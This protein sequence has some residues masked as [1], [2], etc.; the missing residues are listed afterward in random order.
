VLSVATAD[1]QIIFET[2][3]LAQLQTQLNAESD[4]LV[5][6]LAATPGTSKTLGSHP[7]SSPL[8]VNRLSTLSLAIPVLTPFSLLEPI[9]RRRKQLS[10]VSVQRL[11][12]TARASMLVTYGASASGALFSWLAQLD[13]LALVSSETAIGLGILSLVASVAAGQRLWHIAQRRFWKD[14]DRVT[15]MLEGDLKVSALQFSKLNLALVHLHTRVSR[16]RQASVN[17]RWIG[18]PHKKTGEGVGQSTRHSRPAVGSHDCS[19]TR[20]A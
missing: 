14:F 20:P 4:D 5:R 12:R 19:S 18:G 16:N 9:Y 6:Q 15:K 3:Q 11:H 10:E 7:F 2:G 1:R 13:P 8:L 17:G